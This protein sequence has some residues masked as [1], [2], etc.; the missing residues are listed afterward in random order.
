[1]L[2]V[3]DLHM[4]VSAAT[5]TVS[6]S[7]SSQNLNSTVIPQT[8][9]FNPATIPNYFGADKGPFNSQ[10]SL[11]G[12]TWQKD[13]SSS[14]TF[15]LPSGCLT[16]A[17]LFNKTLTSLQCAGLSLFYKGTG[18][19]RTI[20]IQGT[21]TGLPVCIPVI[22]LGGKIHFNQ[23]EQAT[24]ANLN[25]LIL[26]WSDIPQ[27]FA[28]SY[29]SLANQLCYTAPLGPYTIDPIAIDGTGQCTS[30]TANACT[31]NLTTS[32]AN[33]VIV[34]IESTNAQNVCNTPTATG[35]TF[36]QRA[37]SQGGDGDCIS[38]FYDVWSSSGTK[39]ITC[40]VGGG[41]QYCSFFGVSGAASGCTSGGTS[42]FDS[43]GAIPCTSNAGGVS[44]NP[45]CTFS[46]SNANDF[47]LAGASEGNN[48]LW[49]VS[50][51][52]TAVVGG[53]AGS[54]NCPSSGAQ[55]RRCH[56]YN[57]VSSTQSSVT[58]T[59]TMTVQDSFWDMFIDAIKQAASTVT[60]GITITTLPAGATSATI[61]ITGCAPSNSTFTANGNTKTYTLTAT[62]TV[63]LAN[64]SPG[65]HT[66]YCWNI[67][68]HPA[69]STGTITFITAASGSGSYSNNTYY[70]LGQ[71]WTL[72]AQTPNAW[73]AVYSPVQ[74]IG[75]FLGTAGSAEGCSN[76]VIGAS[77]TTCLNA[78]FDYNIQSCAQNIGNTW[79]A[80]T[81]TCFTDNT[82]NNVHNVNYIQTSGGSQVTDPFFAPV[83]MLIM[84]GIGA[85]LLTG[86]TRRQKR[87]S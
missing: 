14:L 15:G 23:T 80:Q 78:Y 54:A 85:V 36:H 41:A 52:Y 21:S 65:T 20:I 16:S 51:G 3:P 45:N 17:I 53:G 63:S 37:L 86:V 12:F 61:T 29:N 27:N 71:N 69:C 42:C 26:D 77:T 25:G 57:I 55:S 24:Q 44:S 31:A 28:P 22:G 34:V 10:T 49:T 74:I 73:D 79:V 46:T 72:T 11:Q 30:F 70:Q 75:T 56:E 76:T 18:Y 4:P 8:N 43:N 66:R 82:A 68:P 81:P 38:D 60:Q 83:I 47:I 39:A 50:T 64:P 6:T 35:L 5:Q 58:L 33:D 84:V 67:S 48:H 59:I 19:Q 7:T 9:S 87:W 62:C 1:M 13:N 32:N 2:I 40:N